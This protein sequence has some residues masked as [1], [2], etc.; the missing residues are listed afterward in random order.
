M[1]AIVLSEF[2]GPEN[3]V[4]EEVPAPTPAAGEVVVEVVAAALNRRDWWMR[5]GAAP[6]DC[7]PAVLGSDAAG[8]ITE[9]GD[10]VEGLAVG[11]SVVVNPS[12]YWG[13]RED[14]P[15]SE[16]QILG[17]PRQGTYAERVCVPAENVA[18]KPARLGW[19]EAAA[20]PL[21]A[22]TAW[23]ALVTHGEVERGTRVLIPGA[24]SGL[25]TM[26]IAIASA[27]GAETYVTS[28]TES[29]IEHAVA[30]G[31]VAGF[32]YGDP[33]WPDRLLEASGGHRRG[34]RWR[35]TPYVD[36]SAQRARGCRPTD[37]LRRP[38]RR[39]R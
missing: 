24:G 36:W 8:R 13:E 6:V 32:D 11:D 26:A 25:S 35:R 3:L 14:R 31:V 30:L 27:L 15:G 16:F 10:G 18:A 12:L 5:R 20:L 28:S 1:R 33:G 21:A 4:L 9:L 23:R 22:L 19:E 17:V 7:L 34:H 37:Q 38:R 29:K 2:G 39:H